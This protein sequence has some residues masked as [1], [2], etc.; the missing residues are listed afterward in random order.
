MT[1]SEI[2]LDMIDALF[3][4][5][6]YDGHIKQ[7]NNAEYRTRCCFCG[8]STTN[9]NIGKLYI[10]ID[11]NDN[12]PMIYHCFRCDASGVVNEDFLSTIGID[13]INLKSGLKKLNKTSD[14]IKSI[15]YMN[16][17][18]MIMFDYKTPEIQLGPKTDY[19]A[20]RLGLTGK[21]SE[22]DYKKMHVITSLRDFLM[23]NNI[24]KITCENWLAHQIE[25]NY[26]GFLSH[27]SSHILFRDITNTMKFS[28]LKYP[29]TDESKQ[30]KLFYSMESSIDLFSKDKIEI[31]LSEGVMDCLS[32]ALNL[33]HDKPNS[34]NIAVCGKQYITVLN[35]LISIGFIGD[36]ITLNI[37]S[38]ND[39]VFNQSKN[40]IPTSVEYFKKKL[41]KLKHVFGEVNVYYN[42]LNK[43]IGV[44]K[45][46]IC[47]KK[48]KL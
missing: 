18:K 33:E 17:T 43:D 48:Y 38:D 3:S 32:G 21:L 22:E 11:P 20:G 5:G 26:V 16:N 12:L 19:I 31:N 6:G 7:V 39:E 36:N 4:M 42:I 15:K 9:P 30:N 29:I 14:S 24:K 45:D 13:D 2:K 10:R 44:P 25:K 1:N 40:N 23:M 27:G 47:L 41:F 8:D 28:W 37:F 34:I 46:K 35:Y